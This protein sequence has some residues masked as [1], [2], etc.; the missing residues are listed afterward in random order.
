VLAAGGG[1]GGGA[2]AGEAC[3]A[4]RIAACIAR[5]GADPFVAGGG[6]GG[7]GG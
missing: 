7:A 6:V 5:L 3:P 2:T 4:A 1:G